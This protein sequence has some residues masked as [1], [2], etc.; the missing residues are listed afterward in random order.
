MSTNWTDGNTDSITPSFL[1]ITDRK[2]Y[3]FRDNPDVVFAQRP[4]EPFEPA[5][6]GDADK[7]AGILKSVCDQLELVST[8]NML[9]MFKEDPDDIHRRGGYVH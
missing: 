1:K 5:G 2:R 3:D 4:T 6:I 8:H 9:K 7:H